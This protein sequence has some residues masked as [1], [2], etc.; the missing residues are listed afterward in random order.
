MIN[1]ET[2]YTGLDHFSPTH[3]DDLRRGVARRGAP[4]QRP[5]SSP[6]A[7]WRV[8]TPMGDRA[9]RADRRFGQAVTVG[10]GGRM[11]LILARSRSR[12]W[13]GPDFGWDSRS[14]PAPAAQYLCSG[15]GSLALQ[16]CGS[17]RWDA[18]RSTPAQALG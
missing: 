2:R 6:R 10:S 1:A 5:A 15:W 16:R 11:A 8:L 3:A 14:L 12:G 7:F 9:L 4:C 18:P 13:G 17:I